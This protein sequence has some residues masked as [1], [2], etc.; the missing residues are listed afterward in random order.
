MSAHGASAGIEFGFDGTIANTL[1]AHRLVQHFQEEKGAEV[2]EKIVDSLYAQYFTLAAHP[3]SA[4]T[5][6]TA[7]TEAGVSE[8]E[9]KAFIEDESE[10]L[11]DVKMLIREQASNGVD[12][13][14]YIV[15]EGKRR[16]F[17]L[18]GAREVGE[19]LK[20]MESV[21]KESL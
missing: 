7:A 12:S 6:L 14:P 18:E 8:D 3:S 10:G 4:S 13:V 5:L 21:A 9:A 2:A 11:M 19:Y 17:T 16:D 1:H 15:F 20:T